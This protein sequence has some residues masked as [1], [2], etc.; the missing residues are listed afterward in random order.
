MIITRCARA[1]PTREI[2]GGGGAH[3]DDCR[4]ARARHALGQVRGMDLP[5]P[6]RPIT[7]MLSVAVIDDTSSVDSHPTQRCGAADGGQRQH[8]IISATETRPPLIA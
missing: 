7:A 8:D 1:K 6:S 5:D 2:L 3:I 4:Q